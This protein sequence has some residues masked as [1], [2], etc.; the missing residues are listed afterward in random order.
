M[1]LCNR[2]GESGL[3][4]FVYGRQ[5]LASSPLPMRHPAR[6]TLEA[7]QAIARLH[8]LEPARILFLRQNPAAIDAGVFHN[9]VAAVANENVLLF[10]ERAYDDAHAAERIEAACAGLGIRPLLIRV[11]EQ[12]VSLEDA[13]S[14]Y[15]FNSQ[16]LSLA[17]ASMT[18]ICPAEC[19][20]S[21]AVGR[22]LSELDGM[23]TP[24]R[25][26]RYVDVRQSMQNGGGPACLRLRIVLSDDELA[27][28]KG[29]VLL[30]DRLSAQL[31]D[32]VGRRYRDRLDAA[33]LADPELL[34]ESRSTVE[35]L[36]RML[37]LESALEGPEPAE[38][39]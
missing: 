30:T 15:L 32:L 37:G 36:A 17:D 20:R 25:S 4:V 7:S 34:D 33:D 6:Q 8:Q 3:Q 12:A 27:T 9:D 23:N 22:F 5:A 1:R 24:I 2:H 39:G 31:T 11:A 29:S 26:I 35:E 38:A 18:L 10:H 19:R 14:S 28:V 16:L 13:V 21:P